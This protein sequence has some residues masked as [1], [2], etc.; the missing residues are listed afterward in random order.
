MP[1]VQLLGHAEAAAPAPPAGEDRPW[2]H[3]QWRTVEALRDHPLVVNACD[4]GT[5]KTEAALRA[6]LLPRLASG[7]ALLIAPTNELLLQHVET[8][9]RFVRDH[10]LPHHVEPVYAEALEQRRRALDGATPR[11][12]ATLERV[13]N[14]PSALGVAT[15]TPL[16][17]VTN[18][19]I[20]HYAL[21]HAGY[22][23]HDRRNL[24]AAF[25]GR[26][27]YLVVDEVHYYSDRQLACFLFY[28]AL[29]REWGYFQ[30]GRRVAVLSATPDGRVETYLRRLFPED[31]M[32]A[33]VRPG[34][35]GG[36]PIPT[37]AP[38]R[39]DIVA[40]DLEAWVAAGGREALAGWL[41]AGEDG[42]VI[43]SA[44]WRVNTAHAL[45]AADR[46]FSGALAR[47]TG[48][49]TRAAR[50]AAPA[51]PLVLATPT[52][53]IGYNFDKPGKPRQPLDFVVVDARYADE[54]VQRLGRAG[55]VLGRAQ[56]DY[57]A[58][59]V[60]LLS[61]E[62]CAE[63]AA[64]DG[65][66]LARPDFRRALAAALPPRPSLAAY[67]RSYAVLEAF[68]PILEIRRQMRADLGSFVDGLVR[69]VQETFAPEGSRWREAGAVALWR[70]QEV[71]ARIVRGRDRADAADFVDEYLDWLRGGG[72]GPVD[73]EGVATA[74]A[75]D[76][77]AV[78]QLLLPWIAAE[79][80]KWEA[81][82]QFRDAFSGPE[83]GLADPRHLL[84]GADAVR[85]DL[86]HVVANFETQW[87]PTRADLVAACGV[88][89]GEDCAAYG[90][91]LRQRLA[92][93]RLRIGLSYRE[94]AVE[95]PVWFSLHARRPVALRGLQLHG[96]DARGAAVPL[97]AEAR[98]ALAGDWVPLLLVREADAG[99]FRLQVQRQGVVA[100]PLDV[101]FAR[102]EGS[103]ERCWAVLGTA[104]F[105]LD[106]ALGGYFR[107]RERREA[108][109]P[110]FA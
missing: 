33:W 64:L 75:R 13:L 7:S 71:R 25:V 91:L 79:H 54:A 89:P 107:L 14:E 2:L 76:P 68:R 69:R 8:A 52:V 78:D 87:F 56:T 20:F 17:V 73:L 82:L 98:R 55:R 53:D 50:A 38:M 24:F 45:L 34:E 70:K 85:Y 105:T 84:S 40:G 46:R 65:A 81:L 80:A 108:T 51:H 57:P 110:I 83:A 95:P 67:L 104:A 28:F 58:H 35:G 26:F 99:I 43:S 18:P 101:A 41:A 60:L 63:L 86:L 37:L 1:T 92:Q 21:Y 49:E 103:G 48:A 10:G 22:G 88:D 109:G 42:A 11:K 36:P 23:P 15:G 32:V 6:L 16:V 3:H 102:E 90:H 106:A 74:L 19:D 30:E 100:R 66:T 9:R 77:A 39:V 94:S 97:P 47:L 4:T 27:A 12:G 62:A 44:L 59:A 31:G 72:Q 96:A 93:E 5:G 61:E 29:W